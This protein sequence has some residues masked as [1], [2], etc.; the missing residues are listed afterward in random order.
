MEPGAAI[1]PHRH[2]HEEVMAVLEGSVHLGGDEEGVELGPGDSAV[3]PP[4]A[5]HAPSAGPSGARLVTAMPVGMRILPDEGE[6][7]VAPWAQ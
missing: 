7:R 5:R 6:P 2:D 3:I 4:G 1:A